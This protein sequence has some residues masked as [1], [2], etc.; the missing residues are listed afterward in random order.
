VRHGGPSTLLLAAA[1]V[2]PALAHAQQRDPALDSADFSKN[3]GLGQN[4]GTQ[5]RGLP[6]RR[7]V[8][9]GPITSPNAT[10]EYPAGV[11]HRASP[12][13]K[14]LVDTQGRTLY[15]MDGRVARQRS[16]TPE[17]Y[18]TATCAELW[19]SLGAPADAAP[20]GAWKVIDG[21][22]GPQWAYGN[23]PVFTYVGDKKPGDVKG[24]EFDNLMF[25]IMYIPPKPTNIVAPP[26]V[27]PTLVNGEYILADERGRALFL[28][29]ARNGTC[30][31]GCEDIAPFAAGIASQ[32][33]GA[34]SVIIVNDRPQWAYNG[35]AV[36]AKPLPKEGA[37]PASFKV[38]RP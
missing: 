35:K 12:M 36:F 38:L 19:K 30:A 6:P 13:G 33:L 10:D 29:A 23:N 26:N 14:V 17:K 28:P 24:H 21:V 16:F 9:S 11:A 7:L 2:A 1:L 25:A 5:E 8:P 18:C 31:T 20:F 3:P 27:S 4:V 37:L 32:N 15:Q 34:W 22:L